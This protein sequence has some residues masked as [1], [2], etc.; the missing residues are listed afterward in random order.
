M[1]LTVIIVI[2]VVVL[3]VHISAYDVTFRVFDVC[4]IILHSNTYSLTFLNVIL[5]EGAL[6]DTVR[7]VA[8]FY[9]AFRFLT[10]NSNS[11]DTT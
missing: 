6:R 4:L 1:L 3:V 8:Y 10:G 7:V 2:V 5:H 9:V 11:S